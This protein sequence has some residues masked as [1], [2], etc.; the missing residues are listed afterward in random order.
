VLRC[1]KLIIEGAVWIGPRARVVV[2]RIVFGEMTLESG[3]RLSGFGE[4]KT[5]AVETESELPLGEEI[6]EPSAGL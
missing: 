2:E 3:G 4:V 1:E 6:N 5:P